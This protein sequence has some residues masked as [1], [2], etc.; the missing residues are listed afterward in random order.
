MVEQRRLVADASH[1][2]RTPLAI[3]R[4]ELEVGL[5][6]AHLPSEAAEV[7]ESST[8]EVARMSRIVD[9]LLTLARADEGRLGLA[10]EPLDLGEV[11]RAITAKLRP[12]AEAKRIELSFEGG[13]LEVVADR[14]SIT[15]VAANLVDNAV[16]YTEPGGAVRVAVWGEAAEGGL[17]VR[18]TGPGI[19][20]DELPRVFDRFFRVDAARSR[21][22]GGSGLGLAICKEI[23]Q[24]HAG[25]IW[26]ESRTGI[27]QLL[28]PGAAATKGTAWPGRRRGNAPE[29]G[30]AALGPGAPGRDRRLRRP[31]VPSA[32]VGVDRLDQPSAQAHPR[33]RLGAPVRERPA[34]ARARGSG[35]GRGHDR[36]TTDL[37]SRDDGSGGRRRA[38]PL[39]AVRRSVRS[40]QGGG[41]S[42]SARR[43]AR[44]TRGSSSG[45]STAR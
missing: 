21:A 2:L 22:Q 43:T 12:L 32:G 41:S 20:A 5:R 17:S 40:R 6:G 16:K 33:A 15:Q 29:R 14:A 31:A 35:R 7:L 44:A 39:P 30:W 24:A 18:D 8:E 28:H 19:A 3:M 13:G 23:V 25:R 38:A 34:G 26:A 11:D 45:A 42:P 1:E 4:A 10:L 27:G 9:D 37:A 36:T